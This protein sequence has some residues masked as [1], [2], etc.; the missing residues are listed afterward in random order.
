M[1]VAHRSQAVR[2]AGATLARR[3]FT[4]LE[5]LLALG[6]IAMLS[7]GVFAFLWQLTLQKSMLVEGALE[8]QAA[9]AIIERLEEDL[10]GAVAADS[11]GVAG[12]VGTQST[13]RVLYR[14]VTLPIK[15]EDRAWA[16]GDLQGS[17]FSLEGGVL[18]AA[19]WDAHRV[20]TAGAAEPVPGTIGALKFR[21][22]DGGSW[23]DSFDSKESGTLPVAIEVSIWLGPGRSIPSEPAAADQDARKS[24]PD[25]KPDSAGAEPA[26]AKTETT[27]TTRSSSR[28]DTP[29]PDR[30]RVIVVPDG[31]TTAWKEQR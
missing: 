7:G 12:I 18:K 3:G 23:V 14:S 17:E 24:S 28:S 9:D 11:S 15:D 21:Y 30:V 22:Y 2:R 16:K 25:R 19:R 8:G 5:V 4:L 13:L 27:S 6:L 29:P 20:K 1:T 10:T 31:P 26:K